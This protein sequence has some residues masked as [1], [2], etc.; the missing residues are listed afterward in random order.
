MMYNKSAS[1]CLDFPH[2]PSAADAGLLLLRLRE[3]RA[4]NPSSLFFDSASNLSFEDTDNLLNETL[5]IETR[6]Y[7][8]SR[9][10]DTSTRPEYMDKQPNIT[11]KDRTRVVNNLIDIEL[12]YLIVNDD[13]DDDEYDKY[14]TE[15]I[16]SD[17]ENMDVAHT[18]QTIHFAIN[19]MDR[20]LAKV[21]IQ[22]VAEL[23]IIGSTCL[24][25]ASKSMDC[26]NTSLTIDIMVIESKRIYDG[27]FSFSKEDIIK[28]EA[29][30]LKVLDYRLYVPTSYSF[31][32]VY[33][34]L[35]LVDDDT[36]TLTS[37]ILLLCL[38]S[39][40]MLE[41]L[42]SETAT[43]AL[44]LARKIIGNLPTWT[45]TMI[46]NTAYSQDEI[47]PIALDISMMFSRALLSVDDIYVRFRNTRY[48]LFSDPK[49]PSVMQNEDNN[50]DD[51]DMSEN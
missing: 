21:L 37:R 34:N 1:S 22:S 2:S 33:W 50:N 47:L 12:K 49:L 30:M 43:A 6:T 39:Y 9:E 15:N 38:L 18:C 5:H 26:Q 7:F 44:W 8:R 10:R 17:D 24:L 45:N 51:V 11:K 16:V 35:K 27:Q 3:Q 4:P 13:D 14:D 25:L 20:Y 31:I 28:M 46:D 42:P 41:Y 48:T 32:D 29:Q 40:D 36:L 23:I 19:F